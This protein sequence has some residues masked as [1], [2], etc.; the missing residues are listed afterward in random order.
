[1]KRWIIIALIVGVI[2]L[3]VVGYLYDQGYLD[4]KWQTLTMIF[5]ALAG[6]YQM[7]KGYFSNKSVQDM[8]KKQQALQQ[9]EKQ[10]RVDFDG[11]IKEKEQRIQTLNKELELTTARFELLEEKKKKIQTDVEKQTVQ[12]TQ[13][14]AQDLFG[15]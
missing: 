1:M 2:L 5:A 7:I 9:E 13:K 15:S 11:Q 12:E 4:F 14:D 8:L 6:P 10:H 3:I